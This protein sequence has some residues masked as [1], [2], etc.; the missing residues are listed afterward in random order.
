[1]G[2]DSS[3]QM[4]AVAAHRNEGRSGVEFREGDVTSLPV[5]DGEFS[6]TNPG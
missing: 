1:V 5:K 6:A 2:V 4:L 3:P